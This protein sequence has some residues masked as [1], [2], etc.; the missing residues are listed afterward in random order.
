M[1]V[2][3]RVDT[4][5][6]IVFEQELDRRTFETVSVHYVINETIFRFFVTIFFFP[7]FHFYAI[8][9]CTDEKNSLFF[10]APLQKFQTV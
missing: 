9:T 8:F 7:I 5:S 4:D 1:E 6:R 3:K 10:F 2:L